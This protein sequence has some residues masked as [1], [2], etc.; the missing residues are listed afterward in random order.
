MGTGY[1]LKKNNK[2][3]SAV[4]SRFYVILCI[5]LY[6][7]PTNPEEKSHILHYSLL[8]DCCCLL[9]AFRMVDA[10]GLSRL[11]HAC[12]R[13]HKPRGRPASHAL[14]RSTRTDEVRNQNPFCK[15]GHFEKA[16]SLTAK[17]PLNKKKRKPTVAVLT[18]GHI[19]K[20]PPTVIYT[21]LKSIINKLV[22]YGVSQPTF[23]QASLP[24][25]AI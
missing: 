9:V 1:Q 15:S 12:G 24:T 8:F 21:L 17:T 10:V 16:S 3:K 11:P 18:L 5:T 7:R 20:E 2:K 13:V 14:P 25:Q 19:N 23:A 22:C 4:P 6:I